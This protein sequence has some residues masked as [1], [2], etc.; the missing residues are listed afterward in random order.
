[1]VVEREGELAAVQ[2]PPPRW[3]CLLVVVM[4]LGYVGMFLI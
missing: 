4:A 2:A 3:H 1:M